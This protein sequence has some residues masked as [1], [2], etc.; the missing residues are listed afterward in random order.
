MVPTT[1]KPESPTLAL[2]KRPCAHQCQV[3]IQNLSACQH[4]LLT[5]THEY[6]IIHSIANTWMQQLMK[7]AHL[8][9][10]YEHDAAGAAAL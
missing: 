3:V 9:G 4:E 1:T 7:T 5:I 6:L 2:V 10:V 8:G